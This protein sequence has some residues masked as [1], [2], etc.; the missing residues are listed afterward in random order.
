V[1]ELLRNHKPVISDVFKAVEGFN[2]VALHVPVFRGSVFKGSVGILINFENLAKR[3][4]DVIKIGETGYAWVVSRDGT[5]LYTPVPG[6]TGKSVFETIKEYPSL[7]VMVNEMLK[8]HAGAATYTYDRIGARNVGQTRKYA[9]YM[10]V[11]IGNTFWS[12]SVASAEQD[13]LSGLIAFRNKLVLVIGALFVCGMVFSILGVKAWFIVKEEDKRTQIEHELQ[14]KRDELT[15]VS[16]VSMMGQ[17]AATLAHELNQP[18]GAILR[19]AEAGELF[20]QDP[21]PDLDELRAILEDIRKDDQRASA[22][23]DRMRAMMK[24][25]DAEPCRLDL[26]QLAGETIDLVRSN[27]EKRRVRLVLEIDPHLPPVHGDRVQLQQVF[28]NLLLNALDALDDSIS[29]RRLVT[30]KVRPVGATIEVA[31]SDNGPGIAADKIVR[32]FEPF[33]SSKPDGLGMGLPISSDII[34][35]HGGQLFANNNEAGGATFTISLPMAAGGDV[36]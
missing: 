23:I 5:I 1:Q 3:Y 35:A 30:V 31:V 7:V 22:V 27:A 12:I 26:G 6:V 34:V 17:L 14:Q 29:E 33:Y 4:L 2:S 11:Q 36:K 32:V 8:G 25:R 10:P 18:L 16:R 15:H 21:S 20:L 13:V 24:Q 9:V 28:I 19:N